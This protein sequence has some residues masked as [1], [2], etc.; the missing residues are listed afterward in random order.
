MT[1]K[2]YKS[3][4]KIFIKSI[5]DF[6]FAL[7]FLNQYYFQNLLFLFIVLFSWITTN[8][9]I[10]FYHINLANN[11]SNI[12]SKF[13]RYSFSFLILFIFV[14]TLR[15]FVSANYLNLVINLDLSL[16]VLI[17]CLISIFINLVF[18]IITK[19]NKKNKFIIVKDNKFSESLINDRIETDKLKKFIFIN[20]DSFTNINFENIK[21]VAGIIFNERSLSDE[22]ELILFKLKQNGINLYTHR[23]WCEKYLQRIPIYIPNNKFIDNF[24][25]KDRY[26]IEYRIKRIADFYLSILILLITSPVVFIA[27]ILIY[28]ED[29][30]SFFYSQ[31]R[32]GLYGK[33]IQILKMRTMKMNAEVNG[34]QW[35]FKNDMRITKVGS[36]LR[37]TRIDEL[38]QL[39]SVLN[40][41]MSLIGPRPERPE[42]EI[43]LSKHIP[44]YYLRYNVLPGLSG[45]AQVNYPYGASISDA[46]NKYSYDIFYISNFSIFLDILIF[47]KTVKLVLNAQGSISKN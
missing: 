21:N 37:M 14:R 10:G 47:F 42:I 17:L 32:T 13:F 36:F 6:I 1:I 5:F 29:R 19:K 4:T 38:P 12:F 27:I 16:I 2:V 20:L 18:G 33:K 3:R 45:W 44:K 34:V 28:L 23:N 8:Y 25:N 39:F 30:G 11:T 40:G 46:K 24:I 35:S 9:I 43:E 31:I 26:Q 15:F 7:I 22:E 41:D